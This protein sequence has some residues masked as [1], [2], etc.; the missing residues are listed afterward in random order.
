MLAPVTDAA[1]LLAAFH[2][3]VRLRGRDFDPEHVID[4]DGPVRRSYP[5]DPGEHGA[6]IENP[7]GL[8]DD[9]GAW[10]RRQRDFFVG[11]GQRVEWKTYSYDE[12][13]GLGPM[14]EAAGFVKEDDEALMLGEAAA[15]VGLA[16]ELP[17]GLVVREVESDEDVEALAAL[18]ELVWPGSRHNGPGFG[19]ERR[20]RPDLVHGVLVQAAGG[21]PA[22]CGAWLRLVEGT[23]FG[24]LWGGATRPD[25]RHRG[26][27]RAVVARRARIALDAGYRYLRSDCTPFSRPILERAGLLQV[28]TTTPYV[29]A[30][31]APP[32]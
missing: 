8:G 24:G 2:Q 1:A 7:E 12:P 21:G 15:M 29:L 9:P 14:L 4:R 16:P 22:L 31:A 28:A 27:Y 11:R 6:M 10:V 17:A 18:H 13:A 20:A 26:L 3:Q 5:A 25:H 32:P 19:D 30:P 23:S